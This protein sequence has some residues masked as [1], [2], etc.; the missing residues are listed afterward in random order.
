MKKLGDDMNK[1]RLLKSL[2]LEN[3]YLKRQNRKLI[4][5][6]FKYEQSRMDKTRQKN[7]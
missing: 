4:E 7:T 2:K 3:K 1:R 6:L 5:E